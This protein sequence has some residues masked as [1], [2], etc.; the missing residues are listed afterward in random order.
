MSVQCVK[1][2]VCTSSPVR[3][4]PQQMAVEAEVML[5]GGLRD[6][7]RVLYTDA[8]AVP[9]VCEASGGRVSVS[10]RV[11][12]RVLYAQGDLTRVKVAEVSK[13]FSRALSVQAGADGAEFQPLCEISNVSSRVFNGRLLLQAELNV[14]AENVHAQEC[15]L[16]SAVQEADAEVLQKEMR[17]QQIVGDGSAQGLV[18]G[19]FE[20]SE[21]L[22]TT[23]ALL[24]HAEARVEDIIG[25]ADGK[26]TVTGTIDLAACF[27][28]SLN[29]RPVV[30]SQHS[31]PFEQTVT[32]GGEMGDMLSATADVTDTAVALEGDENGRV[33][34]AEV[35]IHVN[36]QAI[37]EQ[38]VRLI[39]DAFATKGG[40][41]L[42]EG[43]EISLCTELINEQAAESARVQ[44]LLPDKAPRIKTVLAAFA[45]PVLAGARETG[46]KL[47][48]DMMLRTT[49][50]YMTEDSGIPVSFA[51]EEPLRLTFACNAAAEDMLSLSASHVEASMVASDRAE[52]R[53]VVTLHA[54]GAR[55]EKTF[56]LTDIARTENSAHAQALALYITQ[57]GE[58]LWDVMKRY[59]LSEK[60]LK[61]L[62][63][64]AAGYAADEPLP[65]STRLI[66]YKR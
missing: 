39:T 29:G 2:S 6:E 64:Q 8:Q 15:M 41:L 53:C 59:Q 19:E 62:N 30:C 10:G 27:A 25:G 45:Q 35:G 63:D 7:V 16:I 1:E 66:A 9:Q 12:F 55:Y 34:R 4:V 11:D 44:L 33:L 37:R 42:P 17:V 26:A 54:S 49:L 56:A 52:V 21:V 46:G 28:S 14:Y 31:L 58:R 57:P 40:D 36:L 65:L 23:E 20:I 60:A 38:E 51:A 32:L 50:L 22:S 3:A 47:N 5:P 13:D 48:A 18:R 61:A 43:N 24:S